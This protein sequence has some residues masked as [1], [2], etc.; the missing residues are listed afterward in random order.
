MIHK[1]TVPITA[2]CWLTVWQG[3]LVPDIMDIIFE[4]CFPAD[5]QEVD[6]I[7]LT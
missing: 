3:D 5:N 4:D 1:Y 2:Q 7:D 6:T